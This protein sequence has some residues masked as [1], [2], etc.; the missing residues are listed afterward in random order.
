MNI[1]R[2]ENW[3]VVNREDS[4]YI[5]PERRPIY[6]A[7]EVYGHPDFEDGESV[8]TSMVLSSEGRVVQCE[9]RQYT[10]GEP[11][12]DYLAWLQENGKTYDPVQPV[13]IIR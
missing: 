2:I 4:P 13:K 1:V 11:S 5:A 8:T 10:L 6:L 12:A 9:S 3:A 7:G